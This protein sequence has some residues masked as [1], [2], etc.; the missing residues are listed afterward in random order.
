MSQLDPAA[1]R[2]ALADIEGRRRQVAAEIGIPASYWWGVSLGWVAVGVLSDLG[3]PVV[4]TVATVLFGAVHAT[5]APR[6]LD[7]RHGSRDLSVRREVVGNRLARTLL[8]CLVLLG[9][10]TVGLSFAAYADGAAHPGTIAS[11]IVALAIL[12]GGPALV[13]L[14]RRRA[15]GNG[16]R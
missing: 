5:V 15:V 6:V 16:G 8:G 9:V 3:N 2:D 12:A 7:G 1:A 13:A 4:T 11:I 10:V 14:I